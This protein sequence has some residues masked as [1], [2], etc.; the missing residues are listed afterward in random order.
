MK[1]GVANALAAAESGLGRGLEPGLV[2]VVVA[3]AAVV[4]VAVVVAA[5]VAAVAAA[6]VV[7]VAAADVSTCNA[8]PSP[9]SIAKHWPP[10]C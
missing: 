10:P 2:L 8:G 5:V 7:A 4:A 1:V 9:C 6:A 3:A